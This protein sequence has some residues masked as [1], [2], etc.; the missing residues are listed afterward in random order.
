M[1]EPLTALSSAPVRLF[2]PLF[3]TSDTRKRLNRVGEQARGVACCDHRRGFHR[4]EARAHG[5]RCARAAASLP[6]VPR[7]QRSNAGDCLDLSVPSRV[8]I[9]RRSRRRPA[10]QFGHALA[11]DT[12]LAN[13]ARS[14]CGPQVVLRLAERLQTTPSGPSRPKGELAQW[15]EWLIGAAISSSY[16]ARSVFCCSCT[17]A[18]RRRGA[19]WCSSGLGHAATQQNCLRSSLVERHRGDDGPVLV[20]TA[21][22]VW[23]RTP[24]WAGGLAAK[25]NRWRWERGSQAGGGGV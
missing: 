15:T 5:R 4:Q 16:G 6:S 24:D 18:S 2:A 22:R 1:V 9:S 11:R 12:T 7:P 17:A 14:S 3:S 21:S 20:L 25:P 23:S 19:S 10:G 13:C 8:V